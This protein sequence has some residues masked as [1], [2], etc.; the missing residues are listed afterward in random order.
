MRISQATFTSVQ[1]AGY[2]LL[3]RVT[4]ITTVTSGRTVI[5]WAIHVRCDS[6]YRARKLVNGSEFVA[7][8]RGRV[9]PKVR[10][11]KRTRQDA[12]NQFRL[13]EMRMDER[14]ERDFKSVRAHISILDKCSSSERATSRVSTF[15][16][17][18]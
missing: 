17:D 5:D 2:V 3:E 16:L 15:V 12:N 14:V 11:T 18:A 4:H 10:R 9:S 8:R 1:T 7:F 13:T 6:T